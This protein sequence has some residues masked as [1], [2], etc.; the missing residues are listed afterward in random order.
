MLGCIYLITNL[1]NNKKY[2]GQH[3]T[4][5]NMKRYSKHW[6]A[7]KTSNT[8]LYK[9]FKEFGKENFKIETLC[10][11]PLE[12][13]YNLE[14]YYAEIYDS[15]IWENGYN[16]QWCGQ[17]QTGYTHSEEARKKISDAHKGKV[18]SE[19]TRKKITEACKRRIHS[20]ESRKKRSAALKLYWLQKKNL[21]ESI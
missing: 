16:A 2:V 6:A 4:P 19:E 17:V 8:P 14:G 7:S 20:E 10:I 21:Y 1:V 13:L 3:N 11:C 9:A 12:S 5:D 15:Y 18:Y